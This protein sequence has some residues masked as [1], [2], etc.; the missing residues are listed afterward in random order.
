MK[1]ALLVHDNEL[2]FDYIISFQKVQVA[3][4]FVYLFEDKIDQRTQ[5]DRAGWY[6]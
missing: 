5:S 4:Y 1:L 6:G 2:Y 3:L